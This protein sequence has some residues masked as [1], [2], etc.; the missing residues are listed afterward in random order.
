MHSLLPP[1]SPFIKQV[2][3]F[4]SVL[5]LSQNFDARPRDPQQWMVQ[6]GCIHFQKFIDCFDIVHKYFPPAQL[7]H[8]QVIY[9]QHIIY[10]SLKQLLGIFKINNQQGPPVQHRE[11]CLILCNNLNGKRI[12]KRIDT[13]ICITESLC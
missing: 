2:L 4:P 7:I 11:L 5:H 1:P 12:R 8:E 10:Y 9:I 6:S 3:Y 13:C